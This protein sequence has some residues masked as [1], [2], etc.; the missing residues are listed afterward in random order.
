[1]E[2]SI[3]YTCRSAYHASQIIDDKKSK[4]KKIGATAEAAGIIW[5]AGIKAIGPHQWDV[6]AVVITVNESRVRYLE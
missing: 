5:L 2:N 4:C 6:R 1:M 3:R